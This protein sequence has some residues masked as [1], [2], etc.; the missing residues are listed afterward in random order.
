VAV[1]RIR[2]RAV[3]TAFAILIVF[4]AVVFVL[5][6]GAQ[7]VMSGDMSAGELGQFLLYAIFVA[8]SAASLSEVWS[9]IQ[10]GAGAIERIVELLSE[11]SSIS[12]PANP[13]PL[14]EPPHGTVELA[15]VGFHYPSRPGAPALVDLSLRV[16]PGETV[17][18]VGPSGAGKSTIFRL[19]LRFHDPQTG[20]VLIDGVDVARADPG[21]VRARIGLVPQETV[22]FAADVLENIRYGRPQAS[23]DEVR[24]AARASGVERFVDVLPRGYHTF[25]GERGTRLSGGQR[26]RIA[27]AR[28][29]LKD[30][31]IMLL[32]E[33]TSSLD[34]ESEHMVQSALAELMQGR[35]TLVIAHR[36]ATVRNADRIVVMDHGRIVAQGS[37]AAL[38]ESNALYANLAAMQFNPPAATEPYQRDDSSVAGFR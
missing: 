11:P 15:D 6:L 13:V 29:L 27:I 32:D 25:L 3:L 37:H 18:L 5:W 30:P 34:A 1:R 31:A 22:V 2:A 16:E 26:Q 24:A 36:L 14:P 38:L 28:A 4:G 9:E 7:S 12:A 8:A 21:A 17:A 10:R 19:L 35:T 33:A 20:R 23:D